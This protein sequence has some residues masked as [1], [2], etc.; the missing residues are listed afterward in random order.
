ML[1]EFK[2]EQRIV[3]TVLK[4]AVEK[5]RYAHAYLFEMNGYK[6]ADEVALA[7]AKYLLCPKHYSNNRNCENCTQCNQIIQNTF[8]EIKIIDP[9][10]LW[11]KKEQM[12]LLQKDF[13]Q[14][15]VQ[16]KFRIYIIHSADKMNPSAANSILKFLEEP[17]P[18]II[19]ILITDNIYQI[20]STIVSRCQ[21]ISFSKMDEK[22]HTMLEKIIDYVYIPSVVDKLELEKYVTAIINFVEY[23]EFKGNDTLLNTQSLWHNFIN[24][25][26][27]NLMA[28][29]IML[30]FYKDILNV[31]MKRIIEIYD[32]FEMLIQKIANVNTIEQLVKKIKLIHNFKEKIKLNMNQNLLIDTFLLEM[33]CNG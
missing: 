19:A 13:V 11:I 4:N 10:G 16:S 1:D 23:F 9:D 6:K 22:D 14:T 26:E 33:R 27:K 25:R 24:D 2:E 17:A 8:S 30:L 5:N 29:E 15:A 20:L 32:D 7:F 21:V 12:D 28:F 18:N 31:K 3:F